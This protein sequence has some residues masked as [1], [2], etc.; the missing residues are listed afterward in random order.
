MDLVLSINGQMI[1]KESAC[2]KYGRQNIEGIIEISEEL[3]TIEKGVEAV[4]WT[5]GVT[6][7][8]K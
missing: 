6:V 7:S 8:R 2:K 4:G 5:N 1:D 3:L